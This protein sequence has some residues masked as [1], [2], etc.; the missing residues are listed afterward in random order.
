MAQQIN[1]CTPVLLAPQNYFSAATLAV[2][3]LLFLV[4]GGGLAWAWVWNLHNASAEFVKIMDNQNREINL[5]KE[6]IKERRASTAP[7]DPAL[8]QQ[9]ALQ[10]KAVEERKQLLVALGQGMF[11]PG[12]GH[13]DRLALVANSIPQAAWVT[14]ITAENGRF[15]VA[16]QTLDTGVLTGWVEKLA[17]SPLMRGL[18][19]SAV[20]VE[21]VTG[22][23]HPV[24]SFNLAHLAASAPA[25]R[26]S[27]PTSVAK[28]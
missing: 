11:Q 28:P 16:G 21:S 22:L 5:L 17:L 26:P 25:P 14:E 4:L 9:L 6:A 2:G 23:G 8:L 10:R 1:L 3:L 24:W 18:N 7:A 13:S 15:E 20:K 27:V 19:L 12:E